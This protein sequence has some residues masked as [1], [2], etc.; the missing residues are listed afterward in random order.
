MT[1]KK[2]LIVMNKVTNMQVNAVKLL[3][4]A[5]RVMLCAMALL[6]LGSCRDDLQ[7]PKEKTS[8]QTSQ[9]PIDNYIG[10]V[11]I[12]ID[13]TFESMP[14]Q[15]GRGLN[16]D[17]IDRGKKIE[18]DGNMLPPN[19][20]Y[21]GE[22]APRM[23]LKEGD[24]G[25]GFLIFYHNS[26]RVVRKSVPFEVIEGVKKKDG[27]IDPKAKNRVRFVGE[28]DFPTG[29]TL[30]DEFNN[31]SNPGHPG[32]YPG[33]IDA[34]NTTKDSGW[35]VMAMIGYQDITSYYTDKDADGTDPDVLNRMLIGSSISSRYE[36]VASESYAYGF[37]AGNTVQINAPCASAWMP[38]Y[39]TKAPPALNPKTG[40]L[41]E[42]PVTG[43]NLE[44]YLKPQGVILQY[45]LASMAAET[46]DIRRLGL[47]SNVLDFKG[48]YDLNSASIKN[49]FE[50]RDDKNYGLPKWVP[51]EPNMEDLSMNYAPKSA[52]PLSFGDRVFPW[53]MPTL[54]SSHA[55]KLANWSTPG[56]NEWKVE[57]GSVL[58]VYPLGNNDDNTTGRPKSYPWLKASKLW[59]FYPL[60]GSTGDGSIKGER[61]ILYF[62]GM[63]RTEERMPE[64]GKRA[65]Y[66]FASSYSLLTDEDAWNA[67]DN[68]FDTDVLRDLVNL[69]TDYANKLI[70]MQ[71]QVNAAS[72]ED[73]PQLKANYEA[74]KNAYETR[75]DFN[76]YSSNFP[77]G[78]FPAAR[79][80][81]K[82]SGEYVRDANTKIT[83]R[84][85]PLMVLHQTNRTFP[86][87]KVY[88]AQ[89]VIRPDLMLS[90]VIYQKRDGKNYSL[91]EVYNTTVEPVDLSQYAVVRLI[92]STDKSYLAFRNKDGLPVESLDQALVL[93]LTA[94]KGDANPFAGSALSSLKPSEYTYD[95]AAN[96]AR[97]IYYRSSGPRTSSGDLWS[98]IW[99]YSKLVDESTTHPDRSLY[100]MKGQNILLGAS[101]YV[102]SPVTKKEYSYTVELLEPNGWFKPLHG[103]LET[104]YNRKYLRYAYAYADGVKTDNTFGAG[105]LDYEPG[106]AFA[107]IK[108]TSTGWQIIDATGPV[109]PK[110]LAFAG[111]YDKFKAEMA[112]HGNAEHFSLQRLDGVNYPFIAPFRTNRL[113]P[114]QWSDDWNILTNVNQFTPGRRFDYAGQNLLSWDWDGHIKRTPIDTKFTTYQDARPTKGH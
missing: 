41:E 50:H 59:T 78:T 111:T 65:T 34:A 84:T 24:K 86:E 74:Y 91:L 37:R 81:I 36:L 55:T 72:P 73:E 80:A 67:E 94:L 63:P 90:E 38:L 49:A 89:V 69:A 71:K 47:V 22:V 20:D 106:D 39:I 76:H 105:T 112:K 108:K 93:P 11:D 3:H 21:S 14:D 95:D 44:L 58:S 40:Q 101:G 30:T 28:V 85:Q 31:S 87:R 10:K 62:W 4:R 64:E 8:E 33:R 16:F 29:V 42:S 6:A 113:Y 9:I 18:A 57:K 53:D 60:G 109:G 96:R 7:E 102:N 23:A 104:N 48:Y 92:P 19:A 61:K 68:K 114:L 77:G 45:D 13:A 2:F 79:A 15:A 46:Q 66:L 83:P 88:H 27:T 70:N 56:A 26:G 99:S 51:D 82:K 52:S 103:L 32:L 35:H 17:L 107:L 5:G 110:H 1:S 43:V 25:R 100:L 75:E 97:P 12:V 54:S 98:G